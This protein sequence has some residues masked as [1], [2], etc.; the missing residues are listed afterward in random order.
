MYIHRGRDNTIYSSPVVLLRQYRATET[1]PSVCIELPHGDHNTNNTPMATMA[2]AAS[3]GIP[4]HNT[5]VLHRC[6]TN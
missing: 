6:S 1:P 4:N 5:L 3:G 2:T